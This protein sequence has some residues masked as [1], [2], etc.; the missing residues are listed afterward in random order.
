LAACDLIALTS[1]NEASPVS[2]LEALAAGRPV[3]AS[4]VGSVRESVVDGETGRLFPAGD[5]EAYATL[6]VELLN[7][8]AAARRMG[9]EGRRRVVAHGS[10]EAM[11]RGYERLIE[12]L[13]VAR[14]R[15]AAAL[16]AAPG[17]RR[18]AAGPVQGPA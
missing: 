14:S 2:I 7:N 15:T 8:P 9:A 10:L 12:D 13:Y 1:H 16:P 4:D 5:V 11:V 18:S 17:R 3:V 6:A